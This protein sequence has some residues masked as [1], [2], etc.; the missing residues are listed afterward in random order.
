M[1]WTI[2]LAHSRVEFAVRRNRGTSQAGQFERIGGVIDFSDDGAPKLLEAVIE[3]RGSYVTATGETSA[4]RSEEFMDTESGPQMTFLSALIEPLESNRYIAPGT[5]ELKGELH[6]I[7]LEVAVDDRVRDASGGER[8]HLSASGHL[9]LDGWVR[10][11]MGIPDLSTR[12]AGEEV[13]LTF[14][15]EAVTPPALRE[16][17][18]LILS[19]LAHAA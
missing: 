18:D 16:D 5:L 11:W 19:M 10:T 8:V 7:V 4:D 9:Q 6:P 12:I 13:R 2:D 1:K 15:L 14:H 17:Y 3:V